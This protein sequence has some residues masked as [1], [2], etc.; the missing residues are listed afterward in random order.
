MFLIHCLKSHVAAWTRVHKVVQ[1]QLLRA[2]VNLQGSVETGRNQELGVSSKS[3]SGGK[4]SVFA[5]DLKEQLYC[6]FD[7]TISSRFFNGIRLNF[8]WCCSYCHHK[9]HL[10]LVP[11]FAKID[12]DIRT[13]DGQVGAA[14]VE[15]KIP[16]LRDKNA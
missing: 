5:Q 7:K 10:E 12:A 1:L 3:D 11:L 4:G 6:I 15:A 9:S 8:Y 13:S 14:A 16:H 2:S